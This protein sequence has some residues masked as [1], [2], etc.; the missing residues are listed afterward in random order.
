MK[1]NRSEI[2]KK[3]WKFYRE[4]KLMNDNKTFAECLRN[5]WALAK[6]KANPMVN[7]YVIPNWMMY[8]KELFGVRP[9]VV[10]E[11]MIER[12]TKKA[13]KVY[14]EWIPKSVCTV[15]RVAA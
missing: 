12:E 7:A 6:E 3:A 4:S 13:F 14:G 1:Y 15:T 9:N 5:A 2:M 8:E 10:K 11:T